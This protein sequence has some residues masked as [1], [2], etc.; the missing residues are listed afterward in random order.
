MTHL[1]VC[2]P[3]ID[4]N[5]NLPHETQLENLIVIISLELIISQSNVA[6]ATHFL[7]LP[8]FLYLASPIQIG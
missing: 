1:F 8:A 4:V 2:G 3:M 5:S 6:Q 7:F